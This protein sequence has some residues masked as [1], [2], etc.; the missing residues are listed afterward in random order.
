MPKRARAAAP[1]AVNRELA[2]LRSLYNRCREDLRIYDGPTPR[3]KLL[4]ENGGRLRFLDVDEEKAL[5]AAAAE[6]LRTIILLG[7]HTGLRI[8]SEAL[9]LQTAD[10][11]L[12]RGLLTVPAAEEWPEPNGAG[13]QHRA[14]GARQKTRGTRQRAPVRA[15]RREA[16]P[17]SIRRRFRVAC[18][19]T[20]LQDVTPHALR[21]TF[22]SR[23][24]D[25]GRRSEDDPGARR[26]AVAGDGG[27]LHAP[28]ADAQGLR[29][30]ADRGFPGI[31]QRY[32]ESGYPAAWP[33][34]CKCA[35]VNAASR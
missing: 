25:G 18:E 19:A 8:K 33:P 34:C 13:Q 22:A 17:V 1:V 7:V 35:T 31:P 26:L 20:G 12:A 27:A 6:P 23:L 10:V 15:P 29:R 3:I 5:L 32:P 28:V 21:R 14:R 2:V 9:Q 11:D 4:K 30:R 24:G 16:I